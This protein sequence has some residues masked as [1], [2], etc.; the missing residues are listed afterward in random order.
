MY[1][2]LLHRVDKPV[3]AAAGRTESAFCTARKTVYV[4]MVIVNVIAVAIIAMNMFVSM[5]S[6][7]M[8]HQRKGV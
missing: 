2:A 6:I 3:P 4:I 7:S 8:S 5:S 1:Q